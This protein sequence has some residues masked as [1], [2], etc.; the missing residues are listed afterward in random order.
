MYFD[1]L[2]M[3]HVMSVL[4]VDICVQ[5]NATHCDINLYAVTAI[6]FILKFRLVFSHSLV[7]TAFRDVDTI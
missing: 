1:I 7:Q 4:I 2:T 5:I 6:V 3:M